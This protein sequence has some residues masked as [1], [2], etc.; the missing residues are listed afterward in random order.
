MDGSVS[1]IGT[2]TCKADLGWLEIAND[3]NVTSYCAKLAHHAS[4]TRAEAIAI[5]TALL[6]ISNQLHVNIHMDSQFKAHS[7]NFYN[8]AADSLAKEGA[9][10][11]AALHLNFKSVPNQLGM[12]IWNNIGPLERPA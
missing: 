9:L 6:T 8:D 11:P 2:P 10:L 3:S 1:D 7:N 4:S 5:F 12:L